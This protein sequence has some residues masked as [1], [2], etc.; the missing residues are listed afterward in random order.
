MR[1]QDSWIRGLLTDIRWV[2]SPID[3]AKK[4]QDYA[5]EEHLLVVSDRSSIEGQCMSYEAT[6]GSMDGDIYASLLGPATGQPSSH[7]AEATGCLAGSVWL[8][9][10]SEFTFQH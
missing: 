10:L 7:Q 4:L 1:P 3:V 5:P 6:I 8:R 9:L 2:Y